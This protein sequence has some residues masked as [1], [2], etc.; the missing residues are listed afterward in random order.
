MAVTSATRSREFA[1]RGGHEVVAVVADTKSGTVAPWDRPNLKPWV[2]DP[3]LMNWYD[4]I[5]AYK[6]DRLSRGGWNDEAQICQWAEAHG[7]LLMIVDGPCWP[8]R[9]DG[10]RWS[11]EATS[12]RARKEWED[13]WER[14]MR[15]QGELR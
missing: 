12:I 8:P 10:D 1:E 3:A 4:A 11:W 13:G 5:L 14:P 7:K 9:N 15:A 6:N 2:T